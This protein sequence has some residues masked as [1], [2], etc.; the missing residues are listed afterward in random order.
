M[1]IFKGV[2]VIHHLYSEVLKTLIC[3][4]GQHVLVLY[5]KAT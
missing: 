3:S 4:E 5:N 1:V 2:K